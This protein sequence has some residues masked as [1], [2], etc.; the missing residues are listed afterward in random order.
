MLAMQ[1]ILGEARPMLPNSRGTASIVSIVIVE[2]S[3]FDLRDTGYITLC[4]LM[5]VNRHNLGF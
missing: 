5:L 2:A 4:I 3:D 1:G